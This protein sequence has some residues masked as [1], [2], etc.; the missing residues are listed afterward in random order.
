MQ[1]RIEYD[2]DKARYFRKAL[3]S[4]GRRN[5]R[6]FPWRKKGRPF[7]ILLAEMMLRR[8]NAKQV[9]AVFIET[10][11]R[12]PDAES[13]AKAPKKEVQRLLKPL[14][15]GWRSENIRQMA[16]TLT[17]RYHGHV[18]STYEGLRCLPGVGDYV[19]SAVCSFAFGMFMPIVDTNTVRV[20]GRY[21]GFPTHAESR[22]NRIVRATVLA[23]TSRRNTRDFN[24]FLL[25]FAALICKAVQPVC[26]T[27]PVRSR[28][29][30][31]RQRLKS[32]GL[33]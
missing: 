23:L 25:D 11:R 7:R 24:Y 6:T 17:A 22:R 19:A 13:L 28:C 16:K 29:I 2:N 27:C 3:T 30:F 21:F 9:T 4:W 18:P 20:A 14:G 15:L 31:G 8:T 1:T 12:Y 26:P 5:V 33:L 32:L 10:V